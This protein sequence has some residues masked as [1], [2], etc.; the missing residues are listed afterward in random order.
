VRFEDGYLGVDPAY[1]PLRM[2]PRFEQLLG[3]LGLPDVRRLSTSR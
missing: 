3:R 1:D 2:D